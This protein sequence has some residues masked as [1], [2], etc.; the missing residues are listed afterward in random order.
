[1]SK[2]FLES[3]KKLS[4]INLKERNKI[5]EEIKHLVKERLKKENRFKNLDKLKKKESNTFIFNSIFLSTF[6]FL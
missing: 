6:H 2:T 1:L 5:I 3:K 4:K